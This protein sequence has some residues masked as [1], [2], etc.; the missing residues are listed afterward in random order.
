[1]PW[2]DISFGWIPAPKRATGIFYNEVLPKFCQSYWNICPDKA[3][4]RKAFIA[5]RS[6]QWD[7]K[8]NITK[9]KDQISHM[10]HS[11]N[12]AC[13]GRYLDANFIPK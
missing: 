6:R 4:F 2:Q 13:A 3:L 10:R 12:P 1:M 5:E 7:I 9:L 11:N 8:V